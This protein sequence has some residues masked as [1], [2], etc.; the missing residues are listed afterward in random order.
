MNGTAITEKITMQKHGSVAKTGEPS[1]HLN[2]AN[3]SSSES[4][5]GRLKRKPN[6]NCVVCEIIVPELQEEI[7]RLKNKIKK[8]KEQ[9]DNV[10]GGAAI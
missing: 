5:T 7:I 2:S 6:A 4:A 3:Y 1:S 8:L 10:I 9:N